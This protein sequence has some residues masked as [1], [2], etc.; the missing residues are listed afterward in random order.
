VGS[1]TFEPRLQPSDPVIGV[2][3][4]GVARAYPL[5]VLERHEFLNDDHPRGAGAGDDREPLLVTY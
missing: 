2:E 3:R 1:K 5:S 4:N